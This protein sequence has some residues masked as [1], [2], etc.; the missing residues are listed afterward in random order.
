MNAMVG[1]LIQVVQQ[2]GTHIWLILGPQAQC[3]TKRGQVGIDTMGMAAHI[4]ANEL[5]VI[6]AGLAQVFYQLPQPFLFRAVHI[7][8]ITIAQIACNFCSKTRA[9][10]SGFGA[11]YQ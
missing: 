6:R 5:G 7:D 1:V 11:H 10:K 3:I 9:Q 4:E 8:F 2:G